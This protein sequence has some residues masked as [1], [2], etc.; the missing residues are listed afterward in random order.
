[1]DKKRDQKAEPLRPYLGP[2]EFKKYPGYFLQFL[3]AFFHL[4]WGVGP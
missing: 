3:Y 4:I 1:M 2:F